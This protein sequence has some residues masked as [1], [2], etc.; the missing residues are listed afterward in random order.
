MIKAYV[1]PYGL[2]RKRKIMADTEKLD[3]HMHYLLN[4]IDRKAFEA[5][6]KG[7]DREPGYMVRKLVQKWTRDQRAEKLG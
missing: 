1:N 2:Y 3:Q 5:A 6:C 4:R 7:M